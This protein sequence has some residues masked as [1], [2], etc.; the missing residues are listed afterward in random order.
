MSKHSMGQ[1]L[2]SGLR[3]QTPPYRTTD[4]GFRGNSILTI[5][6]F[7]WLVWFVAGSWRNTTG[8]FVWKKNTISI[9][10]L[11]SFPISHSLTNSLDSFGAKQPSFFNC[12]PA[13]RRCQLQGFKHGPALRGEN[14][15]LKPR[16]AC[17][18]MLLSVS[19]QKISLE[20]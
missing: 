2:K 6:L 13:S 1:E 8:W 19:R 5:S 7:S 15:R 16:T 12:T 11:R 14:W 18:D 17:E 9:E 20:L 3:N 4:Y 10:N